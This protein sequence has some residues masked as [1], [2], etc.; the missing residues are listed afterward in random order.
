MQ[1]ESVVTLFNAL[2]SVQN[3]YCAMFAYLC[4]W[5]G[6]L[7]ALDLLTS[8]IGLVIGISS[9]SATGVIIPLRLTPAAGHVKQLSSLVI[10]CMGVG[11]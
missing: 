9:L 2:K 1:R 10:L 4:D 8:T 6:T 7:F 5:S 11:G 3:L